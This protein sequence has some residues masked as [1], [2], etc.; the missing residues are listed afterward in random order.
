M[1]KSMTLC[2][3][4]FAPIKAKH[5]SDHLEHRCPVVKGGAPNRPPRVKHKKQKFR[6]GH[7]F[8]AH[9]KKNYSKYLHTKHWHTIRTGKMESVGGACEYC[10]LPANDVHH[11]HYNTLWRESNGDLEALC[12]TCHELRHFGTLEDQ[13]K[14]V[15]DA[16][17][18]L[19]AD[20]ER[21][22]A[23]MGMAPA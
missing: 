11:L 3:K 5:L 2:P 19:E 23:E 17:I 15:A 22:A 9:G 13:R 16:R 14:R 10:G 1:S 6:G 12:R 18:E 4:C 20:Q 8:N 7:Q 21:L